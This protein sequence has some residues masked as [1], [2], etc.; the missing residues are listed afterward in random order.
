M[1]PAVNDTLY[2]PEAGKEWLGFSSCEVVPSPKSQV[3]A[4]IVRPAGVNVVL[5][6][7]ALLKH[8]LTMA[9][10]ATGSAW[11]KAVEI[12]TVQPVTDV[13]VHVYVCP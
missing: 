2:V 4:F 6:N 8:V 7:S 5:L 10:S 9:K 3:K 12:S 1:F 13:I 11:F